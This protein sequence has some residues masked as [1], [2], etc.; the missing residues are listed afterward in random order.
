MGERHEPAGEDDQLDALEDAHL[1]AYSAFRREPG[2]AD[3]D[4]AAEPAA[5]R[6][7]PSL[8]V[9]LA[10]CVY[11]GDRGRIYI[12]PGP[13]AVCVV[14]IAAA[15]GETVIAHTT[16]ELAVGGVLGHYGRRHDNSGVRYAG[17]LPVGGQDLEVVDRAG[18]RI[19][20]PLT[21]D[22]AF[23]VTVVDPVD[24]VW[25]DA[26]GKHCHSSLHEWTRPRTTG[27]G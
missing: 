3:R 27:Q 16:I 5:S 22:D 21:S 8:N 15:S 18:R 1:A 17:V 2:P 14:S 4:F 24:L 19:G 26:R 23:W 12:A 7:V 10:R 11:A 13:G 9:G 6:L 25:T 20:I